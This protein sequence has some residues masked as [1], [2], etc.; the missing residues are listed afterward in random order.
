M[1][2]YS[3]RLEKPALPVPTKAIDHIRWTFGDPVKVSTPGPDASITEIRQYRD[4]LE[5]SVGMW[6]KITVR[7][8]S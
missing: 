1:G 5:L 8:E 2:G 4:R 6:A 7:F 3:V